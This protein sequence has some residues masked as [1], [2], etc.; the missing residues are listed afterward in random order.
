[1]T[2]TV[3]EANAAEAS[4]RLRVDWA[5]FADTYRTMTAGSASH[6]SDA[7]STARIVTSEASAWFGSGLT[8]SILL[9]DWQ[10]ATHLAGGPMAVTDAIRAS[11][12]SRML[13]TRVGLGGGRLLPYLHVG[14]G[15][16]REPEQ[17]LLFAPVEVAG[18]AGGGLEARVAPWCA[19]AVEYDWTAV[20]IDDHRN[21]GIAPQMSG[22]FAVARFDY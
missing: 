20:Y 19:V 18:E 7:A 11:S 12:A 8:V 2:S 21:N 15:Q 1:M 10:G 13:V 5:S 22:V 14:A 9:R 17:R 4:M 3:R 6:L 16:W